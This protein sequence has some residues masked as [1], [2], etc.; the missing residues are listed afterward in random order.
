MKNIIIATGNAGF[1]LVKKKFN[2]F[3]FELPT[4]IYYITIIRR[5]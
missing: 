4:V 1:R 2:N 3:D 5:K